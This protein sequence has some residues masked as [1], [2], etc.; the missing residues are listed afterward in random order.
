ML[1]P[2]R[3]SA[4]CFSLFCCTLL[5]ATH[6]VE[7]SKE[8]DPVHSVQVHSSATHTMTG[9][10]TIATTTDAN[11]RVSVSV[12]MIGPDGKVQS[13]S[14]PPLGSSPPAQRPQSIGR[15]SSKPTDGPRDG[16]SS[17]PEKSIWMGVATQVAPSVLGSQ[18]G[19]P[20][21]TGLVVLDVVKGSP[22]QKAGIQ[23]HD[24]LLRMGDQIL[25]NAPQLKVLVEGRGIVEKTTFVLM[26][27]GKERTVEVLFDEH[28]EDFAGDSHRDG[29]E[30]RQEQG[31]GTLEHPPFHPFRNPPM[32]DRL[33]EMKD[34]IRRLQRDFE[35]LQ[36]SRRGPS[37]SEPQTENKAPAQ[38]R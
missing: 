31:I 8:T 24:I 25:V 37:A 3:L 22:A 30:L 16:Q 27:E 33:H 1:P 7:P 11:G 2:N 5:N 32:E 29:P 15:S 21:G 6:G 9:G 13:F 14:V 4:A 36:R 26:R 18:L 19:F 12:T 23:R 38:A 34:G 17:P 10:G 28:G 35:A 20:K